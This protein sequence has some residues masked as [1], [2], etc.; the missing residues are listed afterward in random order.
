MSGCSTRDG[1]DFA[2]FGAI[3]RRRPL[4]AAL[5]F[6]VLL[7]AV[8]AAQARSVQR[9]TA[10]S[11]SAL[12]VSGA[13][14]VA[15]SAALGPLARGDRGSGRRIPVGASPQIVAF[16]RRTRTL[17]VTNSN[18]SSVSVVSTA[19]CNAHRASGCDRAVATIAVGLGPLGVAVNERT[20]TIYVANPDDGTLRG[21]AR[22][23]RG[24]AAD[25]RGRA[26]DV[27]RRA[28]RIGVL[29]GGL[30]HSCDVCGGSCA[31]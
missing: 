5:P 3:R 28:Q 25:A 31:S 15:R 30:R 16:N 23:R 29:A 2:R 17:Y 26:P 4:A 24:Q 10:E 18:A 19:A 13:P 9:V 14:L 22:P 27:G 21:A 8:P 11:R 6:L 20:D 1:L 12:D 7:A